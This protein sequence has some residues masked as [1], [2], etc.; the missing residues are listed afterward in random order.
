MVVRVA[1]PEAVLVAVRAGDAVRLCVKVFVLV[2]VSV[3]V[4]VGVHVNDSL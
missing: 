2:L 3:D 4:G 1:V